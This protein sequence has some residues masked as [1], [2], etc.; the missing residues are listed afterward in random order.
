MAWRV[1]I[2]LVLCAPV[3]G[4]WASLG[5]FGGSA[6]V[7]VADPHSPKT[8]IAG[9][10]NAL[11]FRSE[12]AGESWNP[13]PFPAQLGAELHSFVIDPQKPGVYF[14]GL[15]SELPQF[16]G[17]LRSIDDGTTWEQAPDLRGR[18]VR[19]I[20]FWRGNSQIILAGTEIGVFR[21]EDGGDTWRQISPADN[22]QLQP[23]VSLAIDPKDSDVIY[24]GTPHL[25][26]KTTDGGNTWYSIHDGMLDDSDVFSIQVDRNRPQRVFASACSGIYRSLN[27][28]ESWTRLTKAKDISDR[29]YVIVQDPQYENVW[30]AGTTYGMIRSADGGT[31][32]EKLGSLVTRSIAFDPGRLGRVFIATDEAGIRRSENNGKTWQ[33]A[34][35]GFCNRSL[36][37]LATALDG[38]LYTVA[39]GSTTV[40]RL[41]NGSTEWEELSLGI[42]AATSP[43][44]EEPGQGMQTDSEGNTIQARCR[45]PG[46]T[47]VLFA[48][49]YGAVYTSADGGRSWIKLSPDGWPITSV[50]QLTVIPGSP[51]R[52]FVLTH[53][54]G[55]YLLPLDSSTS[56]SATA[57]RAVTP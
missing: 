12:D 52:L 4:E 44:P 37:S 20:T 13:L 55:V 10:R 30:F 24:V 18:Q 15:S 42:S 17:M 27:G 26:W 36:S 49:K 54:Q 45:H 21:S 22:T 39:F 56:V 19:A 25:P 38:E 33:P 2:A 32:W 6:S 41:P 28:G 47:S 53:Q 57:D 34:N 43:D 1:G 46:R 11:L 31:T 23:I 35:Q 9:T 16:S 7:V 8:F 14:A 5:P 50:K 29:T 40:F 48:A 51:D 3:W